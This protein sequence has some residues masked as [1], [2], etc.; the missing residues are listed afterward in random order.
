MTGGRGKAG[1]TKFAENETELVKR[2]REIIG[3]NIKGHT[4]HSVMIVEKAEV[5]KEFYLSILLD[6][7]TKGPVI[8]FSPLGGVE[9]EQVAKETPEM[10]FKTPIHPFGGIEAYHTA[11]IADKIRLVYPEFGID[12]Q[13]ELGILLRN[14]YALFLKSD[15]LLCEVNPLALCRKDGAAHLLALDGKVSVDDSAVKRQPWLAEYTAAMP[16]H[17]LSREAENFGFLYIPCE[18][19]GEIAV[20]SN[21]S[22]MLMSC[23]DLITR[24]GMSVRA[25]LDLGGGATAERI[26]EAVRIILS[27][28]RTRHLFINIFG[29]I[30]RCDEVAGGIR[31]AYE[32]GHLTKP[33]I[34]RFE[35]TN[36]ARGL[37]II[38]GIPGVTYADSLLEGVAVLSAEKNG[39]KGGGR[40]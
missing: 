27:D 19:D 33:V 10:I 30:T 22:G 14:L 35:G 36:K 1:G 15:C 8:I 12:L 7:M 24:D 32:A 28:E 25:V 13:K 11:Y 37:E 39:S 17:P 23:I 5:I 3:M 20:M 38:S 34:L 40:K 31:R 18:E 9:I 2:T 29:G 26:Q 16:K 6:R 21:G 4:V